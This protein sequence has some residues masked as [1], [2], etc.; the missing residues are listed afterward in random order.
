MYDPVLEQRVAARLEAAGAAFERKRMFGGICFLVDDKMCVGVLDETLMVRFDPALNEQILARE[1][2]R[3]MDFT[4]R[5]MRGFAFVDGEYIDDDRRLSY[6]IELALDYNPR[7][8]RS[9]KKEKKRNG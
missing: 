4:K 9:A 1:D 6:W 8:K 7:A 5:A 3:E 2:V